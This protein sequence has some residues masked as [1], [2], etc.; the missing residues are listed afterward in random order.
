M[1]INDEPK[2][3][4]IKRIVFIILILSLFIYCYIVMNNKF[5]P[6]A[7]YPYVNKE[8]RNVILEHMTTEDIDYIVS[9]KI[10]PNQFMDFIKLDNF[11]AKN[12]L[13][14]DEAYKTRKAKREYIINF[15]N[16][17]VKN[18][19]YDSLHDYLS[20]YTY[21]QL[22]EFYGG[23]YT[24][25]NKADLIKNPNI[26]TDI[27]SSETLYK[28]VPKDLIKVSFDVVPYASDVEG[29]EN[30]KVEKSVINPL[31]MMTNAME[32]DLK[33]KKGGLILTEGYLSYENQIKLYNDKLLEYGADDVDKYVNYPGCDEH[34]LGSV[35]TFRVAKQDDISKTKQY[36]WLKEN[37]TKYGFVLIDNTRLDE[38]KNENTKKEKNNKKTSKSTTRFVTLK[39]IGKENAD[40]YSKTIK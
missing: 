22:M 26:D 9:Q 8:N 39:Y 40:D 17:N 19:K 25:K 6:L 21:E 3:I 38:V 29:E 15:I 4:V 14:Y 32:K 28:Y 12:I 11:K 10:K 2:N 37:S 5:D 1:R 24:Y 36:K 27:S 23:Q 16:A 31:K 7:R 34:Q 33:Q 13:Y 30:I 18:I 20:N 35:L